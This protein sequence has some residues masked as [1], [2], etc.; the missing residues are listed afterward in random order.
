MAMRSAA[1]SAIITVVAS[2]L[3]EISRDIIE[4]GRIARIGVRALAELRFAPAPACLGNK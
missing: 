3:E 1:F 4:S 2:V